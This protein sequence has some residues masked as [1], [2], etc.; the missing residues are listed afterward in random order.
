MT[1]NA[2]DPHEKE[3]RYLFAALLLLLTFV[4]LW[5]HVHNDSL[6]SKGMEYVGQVLGAMFYA[7][8]KSARSGGPAN[9]A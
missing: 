6:A 2:P 1:F 3:L 8:N 9:A 5:S 4:A 7:M